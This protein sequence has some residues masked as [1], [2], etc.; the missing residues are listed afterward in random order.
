M[1]KII[2]VDEQFN[3]VV[4]GY[5]TKRK[6]LSYSVRSAAGMEHL[7]GEVEK[8]KLNTDDSSSDRVRANNCSVLTSRPICSNCLR[9]RRRMRRRKMRHRKY[10][11][12]PKKLLRDDIYLM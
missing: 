3:C 7:L 9:H 10:N 5:S 8:L 1:Q 12:P 2:V 4:N 6:R 11:Y